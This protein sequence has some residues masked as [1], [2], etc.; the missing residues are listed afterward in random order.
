MKI[1]VAVFWVVTRCHNP[2]DRDMDLESK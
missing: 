2:E 1:E